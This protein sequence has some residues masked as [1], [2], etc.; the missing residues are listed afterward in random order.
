MKDLGEFLKGIAAVLWP[1]AF[2]GTVFAF[3]RRLGA[4]IDSA[5][6]R[7]FTL[8][9]AGQELTMEEASK[10]QSDLITD[11]QNQVVALQRAMGQ[12]GLGAAAEQRPLRPE[13]KQ[14]PAILWVDDKPRNNSLIVQQLRDKRVT[15]DLA[16]STAEALDL[17]AQSSYVAVV[18]D[19]GRGEGSE[20]KNDAGIALLTEMKARG[21]SV[22]VVF[23]CSGNAVRQFGERS[24]ALGAVGITSSPAELIGHLDTVG[25]RLGA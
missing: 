16:L 9:V 15:V 21:L 1:L 17:L 2:M 22:P 6:S 7:R 19:M 24:R 11:L 23:F 14:A 12:L 13:P 25:V 3:R 8:K 5:R 10:Q 4:L 20:Y 18:S